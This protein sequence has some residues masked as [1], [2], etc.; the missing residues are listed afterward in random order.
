VDDTE[1]VDPVSLSGCYPGESD[2]SR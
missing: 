1:S 2:R